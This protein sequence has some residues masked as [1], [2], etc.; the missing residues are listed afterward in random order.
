MLLSLTIV[1]TALHSKLIT[2][3]QS[4]LFTMIR[5]MRRC[6]IWFI[7]WIVWPELMMYGTKIDKHLSSLSWAMAKILI[8]QIVR[9]ILM[10]ANRI[11]IISLVIMIQQKCLYH[12]KNS[13]RIHLIFLIPTKTNSFKN[14][15]KK[16]KYIITECMSTIS[17]KKNRKNKT[18]RISWVQTKRI[19]TTLLPLTNLT[20]STSTRT[21]RSLNWQIPI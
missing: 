4:Y 21:L 2:E 3:F 7:I 13:F 19:Q 10:V 18:F 1:F 14:T 17:S 11:K 8:K 20:K 15:S 5:L 16:K 12:L 6:F 9:L